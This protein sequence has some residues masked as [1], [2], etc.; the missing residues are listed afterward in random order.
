MSFIEKMLHKMK[1]K[2]SPSDPQ[3]VA[4]PFRLG[5]RLLGVK[6]RLAK[7]KSTPKVVAPGKQRVFEPTTGLRHVLGLKIGLAKIKSAPKL[8]APVN[9]C[10]R[11]PLTSLRRVLGVAEA[12]STPKRAAPL[13]QRARER[14]TAG[15]PRTPCPKTKTHTRPALVLNAPAREPPRAAQRRASIVPLRLPS[16]PRQVSVVQAPPIDRTE[17]EQRACEWTTAKPRRAL[18]VRT[19]SSIITNGLGLVLNPSPPQIPQRATASRLS[20]RPSAVPRRVTVVHAAPRHR[21]V[22]RS[23]NLTGPC[24]RDLTGDFR[25]VLGVRNS[26]PLNGLGLVLN[27]PAPPVP[28]QTLTNQPARLASV[29]PRLTTKVSKPPAVC[30]FIPPRYRVSSM[31]PSRRY[32]ALPDSLGPAAVFKRPL[33]R[34]SEILMSQRGSLIKEHSLRVTRRVR[35]AQGTAGGKEDLLGELEERISASTTTRTR[36]HAIARPPPSFSPSN[37]R[38]R[39]PQENPVQE[40]RRAL[41][42]SRARLS[43]SRLSRSVPLH[44]SSA[45]ACS[46]RPQQKREH[47]WDISP[48]EELRRALALS[49]A[50]LSKSR[51]SMDSTKAQPST[52]RRS[53][54]PFAALPLPN[55]SAA[56][57]RPSTFAAS[58]RPGGIKALDARS[59]FQLPKVD[60]TANPRRDHRVSLELAS[61][62]SLGR[63]RGGRGGPVEDAPRRV[64]LGMH[65]KNTKSTKENYIVR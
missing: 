7:T 31:P 52:S 23:E 19:S 64:A 40:F 57:T 50:R 32:A 60:S 36:S 34:P 41:A 38:P 10:A 2:S 53:R 18:G 11:D 28:Q 55:S 3:P 43:E 65:N 59:Q 33:A 5:I 61:L 42:L 20:L 48:V 6:T 24:A 49:R 22:T 47:T 56:H 30:A 39:R 15:L 27:M 37:L 58:S 12:E 21:P 63:V 4:S 54:R 35:T 9:R 13:K 46:R 45:S 44:N 8:A 25:R 29:A 17:R 1:R 62:R 26:V 16:V 14:A 51:L